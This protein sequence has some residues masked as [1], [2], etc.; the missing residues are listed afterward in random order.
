MILLGKAI[1]MKCQARSDPAC[2]LRETIGHAAAKIQE[3]NFAVHK[4]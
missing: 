2:I 4:H 1:H 3:I